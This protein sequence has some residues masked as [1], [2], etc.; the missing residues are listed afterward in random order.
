MTSQTVHQNP[1][2]KV[3]YFR[4]D[5]KHKIMKQFY[6]REPRFYAAFTFQNRRWDLDDK[7]VYYT[8]FSLNGN[9][10]Q[11]KN[12][13]IIQGLVYWYVKKGQMFQE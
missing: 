1:F 3:V 12:G 2:S 8:D 5:S 11:A 9:S 10:G 4:P 13:Q 7:L 6:N